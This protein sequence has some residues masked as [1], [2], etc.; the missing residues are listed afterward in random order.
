MESTMRHHRARNYSSMKRTLSIFGVSFNPVTKKWS[1]FSNTKS[2]LSEHVTEEQARAACR[3]YEA[4]AWRRL[5]A[6]PL[7]DLAHR[8]I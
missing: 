2:I 1:A 3:C 5:I 8:S 7:A 4:A 6:R